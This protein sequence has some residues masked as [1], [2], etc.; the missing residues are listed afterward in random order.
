MRYEELRQYVE[1]HMKLARRRM[2][3]IQ[4]AESGRLSPGELADYGKE[5][6]VLGRKCS[7]FKAELTR[8]RQ[9]GDFA[10]SKL[11][12]EFDAAIDE[13]N[14]KGNRRPTTTFQK[15][16]TYIGSMSLL[17]LGTQMINSWQRRRD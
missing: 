3:L 7:K 8:L 6:A 17:I 10:M 5:I 1:E 2:R 9:T 4:E 13:R 14:A 12:R 16:R 11:E 15:I